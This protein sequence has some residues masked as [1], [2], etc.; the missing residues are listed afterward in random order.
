[1]P[2]WLA[3]HPLVLASRSEVR[4][5][6][7]AGA[8]LRFE[9]RPAQIDER[10]VEAAS[11]ERGSAAVARLLARAK[12]RAVAESMPG[13]L[14]LGADQTMARDGKRFSKPAN[15]GEAAA[16]LREL[17]GR[18]HELNSALALVRDGEVLFEHVDTAR[19]TMRDFADDFVET[20]LELAG[21][22]ALASVGGYQLEGIGV[23]LFEKVEGDYFTI[24]GLPLLPLLNFLRKSGFV[25][26]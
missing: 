20:Y 2:L 5:K 21:G 13:R 18:T 3:P 23:H 25:A 19:L 12:A 24:L 11:G 8:A 4:G 6:L 16:Q 26:G 22:A 15:R 7:L 17:R 1:M 9:T 14:V 10:A